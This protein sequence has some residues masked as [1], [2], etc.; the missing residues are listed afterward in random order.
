MRAAQLG[1][2]LRA[3][4]GCPT[5][6]AGRVCPRGA[7]RPPGRLTLLGVRAAGVWR[8]GCGDRQGSPAEWL[9]Q[10]PT[11]GTHHADLGADEQVGHGAW[12]GRPATTVPLLSVC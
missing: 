10:S 11:P 1:L 8:A 12:L 2:S 7:P 4:P 6:E 5:C 9:S 3:G